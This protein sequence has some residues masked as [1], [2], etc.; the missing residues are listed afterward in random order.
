MISLYGQLAN[1]RPQMLKANR[2][3][4]GREERRRSRR[5][6]VQIPAILRAKDAARRSFFE[7]TVL[8]LLDEYG[9][10]IRTRF[11]LDIGEEVEV[12]LLH[13]RE[14]RRFRVVWLGSPGSPEERMAGLEFGDVNE[15]WD[16][17]TL[18][19]EWRFEEF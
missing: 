12:Q 14:A 15:S 7:R 11:A 8:I 18:A 19:E 4:E 1:G 5:Q 17:E 13:E 10:R 3:A 6:P 9:V 16:L 2:A